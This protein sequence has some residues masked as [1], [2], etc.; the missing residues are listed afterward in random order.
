MAKT[1]M[2]TS[3]RLLAIVPAFLCLCL[4]ACHQS[5]A[6][7][8]NEHHEQHKIVVTNPQVKDVVV[9]QQY[10][11]QIKSRRNI[12]VCAQHKE[13]GYL[14]EIH[15]KEGQAVKAG[16]VLFRIVPVLYKTNL[17]VELA[18]VKLAELEYNNTLRLYNDKVVSQNELLIFQ[19]K[20]L[21]A[22]N[23]AKEAEAK[24]NLTIVRA[25]FDGIIDRLY[26]QQGSLVKEGDKLTTL[27]DNSTMWV[28]FNVP[29]AR[30]FEYKGR[31]AANKKKEV[32]R[33]ELADSRI[34]LM[35]ANGTT[36]KYLDGTL[37]P[38]GTPHYRQDIG[39]TVTVEGE[40]N[41]ETGNIQFRGDF[42]NPESLLR[43]GQTGNILIYRTLHHAVVVPQ[44]ATFEFLDKRY[45]YVV[46]D[47]HVAHQRLIEVQEE[48]DDIF[49][50]NGKSLGV[51]EK[52]ILAGVKQVAEGQKVEDFDFKKP[53]DV[54]RD[55]KH[56]A[57]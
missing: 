15:L 40:F 12:E 43:H 47:D 29:E 6:E 53:E 10:V 7:E 54:M 30:Y 5:H 27:S 28:Y 45:V 36:F 18:E 17:D 32:S 16:E 3:R 48:Q 35:L 38:D 11:C 13:A 42:P 19:A 56:P 55:Q 22:Q 1:P 4:S 34:E 26:R 24:L 25:P 46:G 44:R 51:H 31:E 41:I 57:E 37:N 2:T 39:N 20:L 49:V 21:K 14:E 8:K 50:V 52:I 33:L 23:K 9:T